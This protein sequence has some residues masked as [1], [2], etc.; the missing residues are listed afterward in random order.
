MAPAEIITVEKEIVDANHNLAETIRRTLEKAS[1][2]VMKSVN[3]K[4][5]GDDNIKSLVA[6]EAMKSAQDERHNLRSMQAWLAVKVA[7]DKLYLDFPPTKDYPEGF[8]D[9]LE[10]LRAVGIQHSTLYDLN[11]LAT[12]VA[13][14][15]AEHGVSISNYLNSDRYPKLAE[16]IPTLNRIATG[17]EE[18]HTVEEVIKDVEKA[19]SRNDVRAKYR[20]ER[21][22]GNG[23]I[24]ARSDGTVIFSVVTSQEDAG[25]LVKSLQGKVDWYLSVTVQEENH[26]YIARIPKT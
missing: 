16:A 15:L 11:S 17:E 2:K 6:F 20:N 10:W 26:E 19:S 5:L 18:E 13:P 8:G 23:A 7:S 9:M 21:Y 1:E 14:L 4:G 22:I 12:R 3:G 24:N 25:S